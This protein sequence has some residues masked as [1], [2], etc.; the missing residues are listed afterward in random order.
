M[1]EDQ[2]DR[3]KIVA[4]ILTTSMEQMAR[5]ALSS[6]E[7]AD[8]VELRVDALHDLDLAQLRSLGNKPIVLTCRSPEEGGKFKGSE[9]ERQAILQRALELGFDY[10]DIEMSSWTP[11]LQRIPTTSKIVLSKHDFEACPAD[12]GRI[13]QQA[14]EL[15][16]DLVKLA[17]KVD[18]LSEALRIADAGRVARERG[19]GFVPVAMGPAG[20]A[21]RI[22]AFRLG[23]FW[24]YTSARD[25]PKTGPGQLGLEE[26]LDLYRFFD[27]NSKTRIYGILG[28]PVLASLSPAMHNAYM[29]RLDLDAVYLPFEERDI[30]SFKG[31]AS[32]LG[33]QGLSVTRPHKKDVL[34]FLDVA[35]QEVE[36]VGA[37]NTIHV[38]EGRWIGFNTDIQG[39]AEPVSKRI[40][41]PGRHAVVL[42]AGGAAS[43][44]ACALRQSGAHLTVLARRKEQADDLARR[45][46]GDSGI[47]QELEHMDWDILV[48][49]TPVGSELPA[50]VGR[51]RPNSVVLD[52]V[53]GPSASPL[54]VETETRGARVI[55]GLEM[56]VTQAV[57]QAE[58]WFGIR[59]EIRDLDEAA[60]AE[61]ERR[62]KVSP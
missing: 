3:A 1:A 26:L 59:P 22:L 57:P 35:S 30:V 53:Y 41:I 49:T 16:A 28:Y 33:I 58:T 25:L 7:G 32:R 38:Q 29:S 36:A 39:V 4:S 56:L 23:G 52:M 42:G 17:A 44:A 31:A 5:A 47:L 13:V 55:S 2:D 19:V 37:A 62:G 10:V 34:P 48:N 51:V 11:H 8:L 14:V 60:R 27:I 43:A 6:T 9:P 45:F 20:V 24:T 40:Q 21:A 54:L 46:G 12:A 61:I 18:S 50:H 15:G